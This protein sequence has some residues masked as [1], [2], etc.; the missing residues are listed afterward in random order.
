MLAGCRWSLRVGL[1]G[2]ASLYG[3]KI[4]YQARPMTAENKHPISLASWNMHMG[5]GA[6]GNRDLQR[7]IIRL[8]NSLPA[9]LIG[10]QEVDNHHSGNT[11]DLNLL[12]EHT[13]RQIIAGPTMQKK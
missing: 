9:Q 4:D 5:I 12:A 2:G 11:N 7:S 6:D 1:A 13:G 3:P 10:L 8:L